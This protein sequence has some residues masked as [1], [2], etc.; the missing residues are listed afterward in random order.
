MLPPRLIRRLVLA[1]LV[2]EIA[3]G[4]VALTPAVA[5]LTV[6]F[7]LVRR[8]TRSGRPRRGRL[9]R[10]VWVALA[11]SIGETAAL[12]VLLCLWIAS[13]FGGRLDTEPYR[14]RHYA[15]M[16][17][18]LNLVYRAARRACGL[19]VEV[20]APPDAS[21]LGDRPVIV[22]SRHAGPGDS[23]LLVHHLLT[24]CGRRP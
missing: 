16:G 1:P 17:W 22:L 2:V 14:T 9:L 4:L 23:L 12:T 18:F 20:A 15:V 7:G 21:L 13:G 24:N 3:A 11:W 8:Q 10:V 6:V 19:R 5:V